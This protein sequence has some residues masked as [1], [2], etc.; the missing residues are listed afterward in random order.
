MRKM[1]KILNIALTL[2]AAFALASC[3]RNDVNVYTPTN[4]DVSFEIASQNLQVSGDEITV[5]LVR[6][7]AQNALSVPVS[8]TDPSGI[9]TLAKSTAD[10]QAGSYKSTVSIAYD[11]SEVKPGN[12]YRISLSFDEKLAGPGCTKTYSAVVMPVLT[13]EE[14]GTA[15]WSNGITMANFIRQPQNYKLYKAQY[16]KNYY[17]I[18]NIFG[19]GVDMEFS[20]VYDD[21][22]GYY[23]LDIT[24]PALTTSGWFAGKTHFFPTMAQAGGTQIFFQT[25]PGY[26]EVYDLD[27]SENA[28]SM[29][30]TGSEIDYS[31]FESYNGDNSYLQTSSGYWLPEIM[32]IVLN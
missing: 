5:T 23:T 25:F 18:E 8:I 2:I 20:V 27:E 19:G 1:K 17:K 26:T 6:G 11:M 16:T 4:E 30:V 15:I 10:F 22:E 32:T 29:L 12:A 28:Q 14:V 13:Y 31:M 3:G 24:S 7:V 21:E 9:F